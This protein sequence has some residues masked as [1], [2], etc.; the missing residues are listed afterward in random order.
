MAANLASKLMGEVQLTIPANDEPGLHNQSNDPARH[1][2]PVKEDERRNLLCDGSSVAGSSVQLKLLKS[3]R[4]DDEQQ[5]PCHKIKHALPPLPRYRR[6]DRNRDRAG[7]THRFCLRD[8]G[9]PQS[10]PAQHPSQTKT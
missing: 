9:R 3:H 10:T 1:Q 7:H 4:D 2:N 5:R 8:F 6:A